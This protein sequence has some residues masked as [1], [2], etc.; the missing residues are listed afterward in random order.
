MSSGGL[1]RKDSSRFCEREYGGGAQH[2]VRGPLGLVT[3]TIDA[4]IA[5]LLPSQIEAV[6]PMPDAD[7]ILLLLDMLR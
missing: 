4:D 5:K 1:T 6:L 2:S 7:V 3:G